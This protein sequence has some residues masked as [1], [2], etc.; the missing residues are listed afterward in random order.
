VL[1]EK[2]QGLRVKLAGPLD[3]NFETEDFVLLLFELS[4]DLLQGR[5]EALSSCGLGI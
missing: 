2:I 4:L 5:P 3:G 1:F